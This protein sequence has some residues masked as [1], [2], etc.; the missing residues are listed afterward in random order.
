ML[1][2][3]L[4]KELPVVGRFR[5]FLPFGEGITSD[6]WVLNILRRGYSIELL[7]VPHFAGVQSTRPPSLGADV[8]SSEVDSLLCKHAV[9][10]VPLDQ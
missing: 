6:Q 4:W 5:E 8:L 1:S 7:R 10:T 2:A 9:V 3:S